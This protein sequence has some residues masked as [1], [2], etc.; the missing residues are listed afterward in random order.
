MRKMLAGTV[1]VLFIAA[2]IFWG[3]R[4]Y[5]V[6]QKYP[7]DVIHTVP[8][9]EAEVIAENI[10]MKVI[11]REWL[12]FEEAKGKYIEKELSEEGYYYIV[13]V[14]LIN[15]GEKE[16]QADL[17]QLN[18]ETNGYANGISLDV[19]TLFN[20][21][22]ILHLDLQPG[23]DYS[24][25]LTYTLYD[26]QWKPKDWKHIQERDYQICQYDYPDKWCWEI[27]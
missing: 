14:L 5:Q 3:I 23:E 13:E 2:V 10:T 8:Y 18:L 9:G 15:T 26:F 20:E 25:F 12:S 4:V 21:E 16:A 27:Q 22:P 6:N 11:G 7:K 1:I 24:M 19:F 17:T